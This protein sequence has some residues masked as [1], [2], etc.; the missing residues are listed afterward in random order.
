MPEIRIY[1]EGGGDRAEGKARL[2]QGFD[3]FLQ[4]MKSEA[5]KR[6]V[7]WQTVACGTRNAAY[8]A[9]RTALRDHAEA[10]NILLV[11]S[12]APVKKDP[13]Q[14]LAD[15]DKWE[16]PAGTEGRCHLMA[17]A[18]EAWLI[19][20]KAALAKF[21]GKDFNPNAI[22]KRAD[23]ENIDK[24]RLE[25]ILQEATKATAKGCYHK[26]RHAPEILASLDPEKVRK[27]APH[28]GMLF[29]TLQS[30]L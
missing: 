1:V 30:Q 11:D 20:D 6:S 7:R 18:M 19:A 14:H 26:I 24:D 23:V 25:P 8:D 17:Q 3:T 28:C 10:F 5:R 4:E 16:L 29:D 27:A 2:R 22:P 12:E 21:Y 13:R 9:F 15:R